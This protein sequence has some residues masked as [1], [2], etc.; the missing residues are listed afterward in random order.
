MAIISRLII[1]AKRFKA[2]EELLVEEYCRYKV[3]A[4]MA[5]NQFYYN[6]VMPFGLGNMPITFELLMNSALGDIAC[7]VKQHHRT[8]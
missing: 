2:E 4:F 5:G 8:P 6:V 7:F 3:K 1:W